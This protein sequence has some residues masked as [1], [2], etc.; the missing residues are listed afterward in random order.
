MVGMSKVRNTPFLIGGA[1]SAAI[2][3]MHLGC[4]VVGPAGYRA[5]GAGEQMAMLAES[6]HWYP[7]TITAVIAGAL[8][9]WA[10]YAFSAGGIIGRLPFRRIVLS[11]VTGVYLLRG[12]AFPSLMALFP[13]NSQTFWVVTSAAA[14]AIGVVHLV[15][16]G[17]VW[18]RL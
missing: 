2:A 5:L 11:L 10:S 6:G 4:I 12:L 7:P 1:L 9:V 13:G 18:R 15:G 17:Q 14:L 3:V 16:L 8:L